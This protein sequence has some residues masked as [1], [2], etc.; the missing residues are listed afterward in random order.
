MS[1][2]QA[3]D[4]ARQALRAPVDARRRRAALAEAQRLAGLPFSNERDVELY[5]VQPLLALLGYQYPRDI[6]NAPKLDAPEV[7]VGRKRKPVVYPDHLVLAQG[8]PAFVVDAKNPGQPLGANDLGQVLS[9]ALHPDVQVPLVV[10]TNA[11]TTQVYSLPQRQI[12]LEVPQEEL[13]GRLPELVLLL[14]HDSVAGRVG[15]LEIEERLGEGG[16]G[17]VF[18]AWN[19]RLR[20]HEA[21]KIYHPHRLAQANARRRLHQGLRAQSRLRHESIVEI[22]HVYDQG[23]STMV[24]MQFS[25]GLPLGRW[26]RK[27]RPSTTQRIALLSRLAR[28][29]HYAHEQGVTHRDLKPSNILVE[30]DGEGWKPLVVD[31]DTAVLGDATIFTQTGEQLGAPGYMA[32]ELVEIRGLPFSRRRSRLVD[33]YSLGAVAYFTFFGQPPPREMSPSRALSLADRIRELGLGQRRKLLSLIL[34]ALHVEPGYRQE[35]AALLAADLDEV[36]SEASN[37]S[38]SDELAFVEALMAEIDRQAEAHPLPGLKAKKYEEG[39]QVGRLWT[40]RGL[41]ELAAIHDFD[42][43]ELMAGL[44]FPKV[45]QYY[46]FQSTA[47]AARV[48]ADLGEALVIDPPNPSEEGGLY[49]YWPLSKMLA[50]SPESLAAKVIDTLHRFW[51]CLAPKGRSEG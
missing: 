1:A 33:V 50:E 8:R 45:G 9:Y 35:T 19:S 32:P 27:E 20:R 23:A 7:F 15:D 12:L 29:V 6:Q 48:R 40:L 31:F 22:Y 16:F 14:G 28:A 24:A 42:Y 21:L 37:T 43:R 38:Q 5:F 34:R 25:L 18:R 11:T 47:A 30:P 3:P 36:L 46:A 41:G 13:A 44:N 2:R 49:L 51:R 17:T 26:V 10:L 39:N 4:G